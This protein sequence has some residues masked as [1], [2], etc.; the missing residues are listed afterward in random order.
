MRL[1]WLLF[2]FFMFAC[3]Q[4]AYEDPKDLGVAF[5]QVM[6][7]EPQRCMEFAKSN[8]AVQAYNIFMPASEEQA[9]TFCEKKEQYTRLYTKPI[10]ITATVAKTIKSTHGQDVVLLEISLH[11]PKG[12]PT[13]VKN[14]AVKIKERWYIIP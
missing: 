12:E 11:T 1:L 14:F 10:N 5:W 8:L 9:K 7:F 3:S 6:F 13:V 4:K 2:A